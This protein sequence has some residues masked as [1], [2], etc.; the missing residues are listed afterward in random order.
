MNL[1]P[2]RHGVLGAGSG[3][4]SGAQAARNLGKG[5]P[6]PHT[7]KRHIDIGWK[8]SCGYLIH[9]ILLCKEPFLFFKLMAET[10]FEWKEKKNLDAQQGKWFFKDMPVGPLSPTGTQVHTRQGETSQACA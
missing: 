8:E 3:A 1:H 6:S 10:L 5:G 9:E 7:P 4:E 2:Y